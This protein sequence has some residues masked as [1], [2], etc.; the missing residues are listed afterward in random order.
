MDKMKELITRLEKTNASLVVLYGN[1]EIKEHYNK[2]V[3]D[4]V[5]IIKEDKNAL[6]GACVADKI[7]INKK[8]SSPHWT[9]LK[10]FKC[11]C[12]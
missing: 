5:N 6:F 4:I 3:I 12:A 7:I 10:C 9:T 2:R 11:R 1:D 8:T